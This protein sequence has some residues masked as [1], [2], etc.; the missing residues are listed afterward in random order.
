M[1]QL[2]VMRM[3]SACAGAG[4]EELAGSPHVSLTCTRMLCC[5]TCCTA[6]LKY[7][8]FSA[9]MPLMRRAALYSSFLLCC[10]RCCELR[11]VLFSCAHMLVLSNPFHMWPC[12][13]H[14]GCLA[15]QAHLPPGTPP[16][17]DMGP[18]AE[19][20]PPKSMI[21]RSHS[22]DSG[23]NSLTGRPDLRCA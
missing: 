11:C 12:V 23:L 17:H 18:L 4:P 21:R 20:T 15:M 1:A 13:G 6:V 7:T 2:M 16:V 14:I 10:V 8:P 19:P 22:L 5:N 3:H 9:R